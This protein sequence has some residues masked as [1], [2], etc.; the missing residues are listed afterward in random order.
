MPG[1]LVGIYGAHLAV[2]GALHTVIKLPEG[3]QLDGLSAN[4]YSTIEIRNR[5]DGKTK[6]D[7]RC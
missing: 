2:R 1:A 3:D 6:R 5:F 4:E 7:A